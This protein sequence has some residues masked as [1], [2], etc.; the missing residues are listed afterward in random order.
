MARILYSCKMHTRTRMDSDDVNAASR[1][2]YTVCTYRLV[3][4]SVTL[5]IRALPQPVRYEERNVKLAR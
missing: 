2:L 1:H 4:R 3:F 5:L